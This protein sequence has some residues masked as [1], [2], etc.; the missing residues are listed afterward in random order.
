MEEL[1]LIPQ[2]IEAERSVIGAALLRPECAFE[3][4]SSLQK[5]DFSSIVHMH[6]Y[7]AMEKLA[8]EGITPDI[9][10]VNSRLEAL[11]LATPG[12]IEYLSGLTVETITTKNIK[13]HIDIIREKSKRRR[14]KEICAR[15]ISETSDPENDID[16]IANG[17]CNAIYDLDRRKSDVKPLKTA[18]QEAYAEI[19]EAVEAKKEGKLLGI[20]TGFPRL[21]KRLAGLKKG[22]LIVIGARSSMGKTSFAMNIADHVK[23]DHKVLYFSLEMVPS[24]LA[25]RL[26][27]GDA[28]ISMQDL[29]TGDIGGKEIARLG[30][31]IQ[32]VNGN[33]FISDNFRQSTTDIMALSQKVRREHGLDLVIIDYLQLITRT[34][35][36]DNEV[37]ALDA[38]T[39]Q[40]KVI[41]GELEVPVILLSQL[42]READK[43][44]K[45][46]QR[47]RVPELSEL[48]GSGAI[49]QNADVV[50][51][52]HKQSRDSTEAKLI[53]A[54]Q[55]NGATG[56]MGLHWNGETTR[57]TE[58]DSVHRYYGKT[59]FDKQEVEY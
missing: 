59:P 38:I 2:D 34:E 53:V 24:Q 54:K 49:E 13:S 31:A 17:L 50:L 46:G 44:N 43:G 57:F 35:F 20:Q 29:R 30:T 45:G 37:Q 7:E 41:A 42:S 3:V 6:V 23:K 18:Y 56:I 51:L 21:D 52:L 10:T 39:R 15:A 25:L 47:G 28:K 48:R 36:K 55:R 22:E 19:V 33:M 8:K 9:V 40:L 26:M 32:S 12:T 58:E 5:D 1:E 11:H 27:A 14:L 16:G 4:L